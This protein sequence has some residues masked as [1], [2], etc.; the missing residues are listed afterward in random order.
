MFPYPPW[1]RSPAYVPL[2]AD[3]RWTNQARW[4]MHSLRL[5]YI[6]YCLAGQSW[7]CDV[8]LST[9][10]GVARGSINSGTG[11]D[12]YLLNNKFNLSKELS[13]KEHSTVLTPAEGQVGNLWKVP[14]GFRNEGIFWWPYK[15]WFY[16]N[17]WCEN[18]VS[19]VKEGTKAKSGKINTDGC[20]K[21]TRCEREKGEMT[22]VAVK[23]S[24]RIFV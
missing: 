1:V 3:N 7:S 14:T 17:V 20:L 13:K 19:K 8:W 16:W 21:K 12:E 6:R 5:V 11:R 2:M 24:R 18:Q 22:A 4:Q 23:S 10:F 15:V 9:P